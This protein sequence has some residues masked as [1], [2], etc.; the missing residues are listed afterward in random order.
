[1]GKQTHWEVRINVKDIEWQ[2]ST[3]YSI[4][5]IFMA[6]EKGSTTRKPIIKE[7]TRSGFT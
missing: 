4:Y 6:G 1:M 2:I 5:I 7:A 3:V